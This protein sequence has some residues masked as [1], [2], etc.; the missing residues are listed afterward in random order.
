MM[1]GPS[2][3][4]FVNK[5][6]L[7]E[8]EWQSA[9]DLLLPPPLSPDG[10]VR[11]LGSFSSLSFSQWLSICL[12]SQ[13]RK[14]PLWLEVHPIII[15][16]WADGS[17]CPKSDVDLILLGSSS[18]D[19]TAIKEFGQFFLEKGLKMRFHTPED[20]NDWTKGVE[21]FDILAFLKARAVT[22]RGAQ[23]LSLNHQKLHQK[24]TLWRKKFLKAI[25]QEGKT[26]E[27]RYD[28]IS[29][30]LEP[31]IKYGHGGLRDLQQ[32]M[33]LFELFPEKMQDSHHALQVLQYY[34]NFFILIR[35]KLHLLGLS[36]ILVA[37]HQETL[38][39]WMGFPDSRTFMREVQKGLSRVSFY[40]QWIAEAASTTQA[41]LKKNQ[42]T[43][44]NSLTQATKILKADPGVLTQR[45]IRKN[46]DEFFLKKP[47]TA[48]E[49][50]TF[51]K[52]VLDPK[53]DEKILVAAFRS[54]LMDKLLPE[55]RRLFGWVQH[56]QY[57]RYTADAHILQACRE[58]K[59]FYHQPQKFLA[60]ASEIQ[61]NQRD[62]EVL[63]WT[64]LYHDQAKG[65]EGAH[66]KLG[67][68]LV[69]SDLQKLG[70]EE[71]FI[72]DV[73]WLVLNHLELSI[74]AFKKNPMQKQTWERLWDLGASGGNL[75]R[76]AA[77][78]ALDIKAT[79]P[80]AWTQ[81]KSQ[82]LS[83]LVKVLF[84]KE[85]TSLRTLRE[86]CLKAKISW[87]NCELSDCDPLM[88]EMLSSKILI[89]DYQ[90]LR[91]GGKN[92]EFKVFPVKNNQGKLW[93]RFASPE[94]RS[95]ILAEVMKKIFSM[96]LSVKHA[97]IHSWNKEG[98]IGIYDWFLVASQKA[99]ETIEKKLNLN[100][101]LSTG[102]TLEVHSIA[103]NFELPL[104]KFLKISL[105]EANDQ[106]WIFSFKAK[107]QSGL[108][109][110]A[111]EALSK[112]NLNIRWAKVHTWGRE[113]DDVFGV[114]P[115]SARSAQDVLQN[116]K[117]IE[118]S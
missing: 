45:L 62:W 16:S 80:E 26:R 70:F 89:R 53:G 4:T 31:N 118:I 36:D 109:A 96:G 8:E 99:P 75:H 116:L 40:A 29:N 25:F 85:V 3:K 39:H 69:R 113:I 92:L 6:F 59:R 52:T 115:Q 68:Q 82:L 67:T 86:S 103:N 88:I 107:D 95:G 79:N 105:V 110:S 17:L 51:L 117:K 49:R 34:K 19:E 102:S 90:S 81:W 97:F 28:S 112:E 37:T 47:P 78:T 48:S 32:A 76:L 91:K 71:G 111:V 15:G 64:A 2:P 57:H 74:A 38:A 55:I 101:S 84:S 94:D 87:E 83:Q 108:L 106:E 20:L 14:S 50:K 54:R 58:V 73:E 93:V 12:E 13:L 33:Q 100:L 41:I 30:F 72:K 10:D 9:Q 61:L 23:L 27:E 11:G 56:D 77:F 42:E 7:T 44:I 66:E 114:D 35:Q 24:W 60:L 63:S 21:I 65:K 104:V 1:N 43:K 46:M 98:Q 22:P 18:G 5:S